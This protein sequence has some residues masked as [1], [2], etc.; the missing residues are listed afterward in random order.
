MQPSLLVSLAALTALIVLATVA[1][2]LLKR[3]ERLS[4]RVAANSCLFTRA[5]N[6]FYCALEPVARSLG[7]VVFPKVGLN[8]IFKGVQGARRGQYNR[9]AHMHV[10]YLLVS[11]DEFRPLL[12]IELDGESHDDNPVQRDRDRRKNA[13]FKAAGLPLLRF[14]NDDDTT[15]RRLGQRLADAIGD[16]GWLRA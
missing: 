1:K 8:D 12:G 6:R 9:Y 13:V 3:A 10:D 5:E 11:A 2:I 15:P 7:L 4:F 14:R 16:R